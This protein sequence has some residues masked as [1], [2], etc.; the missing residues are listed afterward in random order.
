MCLDNLAVE[1]EGIIRKRGPTAVQQVQ[2]MLLNKISRLGIKKQRLS[3]Q[4]IRM[5]IRF[6]MLLDVNEDDIIHLS[7]LV[8]DADY[9]EVSEKEAIRLRKSGCPTLQEI[10]IR[11]AGLKKKDLVHDRRRKF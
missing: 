4:K 10:A 3:A 8:F 1:I 11:T 2:E 9:G 6:S 7:P 5:A